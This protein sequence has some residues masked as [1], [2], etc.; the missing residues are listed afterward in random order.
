MIIYYFSYQHHIINVQLNEEYWD[1]NLN[2]NHKQ[3]INDIQFI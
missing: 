3:N 1:I 2:K